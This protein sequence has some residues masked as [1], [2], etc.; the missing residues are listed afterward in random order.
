[1]SI[2]SLYELASL[3]GHGIYVW[4]ALILCLAIM[5]GEWVN[6]RRARA[7]ALRRVRRLHESGRGNRQS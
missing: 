5:L 6:V 7:R 4:T 2:D 3:G 1:M